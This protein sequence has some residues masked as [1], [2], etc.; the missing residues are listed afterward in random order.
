MVLKL[1]RE[2]DEL[3]NIICWTKSN[4]SATLRRRIKSWSD[5][6]PAQVTP[7]VLVLRTT[8]ADLNL[9]ESLD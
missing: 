5:G 1:N 7:I 3:W 6:S 2:R 4:H 8:R 9:T